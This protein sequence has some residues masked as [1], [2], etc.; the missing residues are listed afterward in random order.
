MEENKT[1]EN[2][3][4][5]NAFAELFP[6]RSEQI[7]K[8]L[9][10]TEKKVNNNEIGILVPDGSGSIPVLYARGRC[11]PEAWE[12]L[13]LALFSFGTLLKTQYDKEGDPPS[14]DSTMMMIIE[15]PLAEPM[16]HRSFPGGLEDLEEYR[17]EVC[18]GIKDHWVRDPGNPDDQRW[19]YTY[20]ERLFKYS[21][22]GLQKPVDQ[23]NAVIQG[24]AK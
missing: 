8:V 5:L 1:G 21:V 15:K 11:L 14:L 20:H 10:L 16:I 18:L 17:Q 13:L 24:L 3:D 4:H 2:N 6:E 19:E 7:K 9:K 23:I 12:N 22:P